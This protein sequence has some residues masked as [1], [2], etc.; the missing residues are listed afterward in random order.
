MTHNRQT[1]PN[2]LSKPSGLGR[3][4]HAS[5]TACVFLAL[6]P[7][8]CMSNFP[9]HESL[10]SDSSAGASSVVDV[11]EQ[12]PVEASARPR[13][14]DSAVSIWEDPLPSKPSHAI[15]LVSQV[16]SSAEPPATGRAVPES[17]NTT[18]TPQA[19]V[20]DRLSIGRVTLDITPPPG[21]FPPDHAAARF[22][23]EPAVDVGAGAGREW[24]ISSYSWTAPALCHEP[25]YFEERGLERHGQRVP[26]VQ[27]LISAVHF[28]GRVP[29]LPYL[30]AA[31][32]PGTPVSSLGQYRPGSCAPTDIE[33]P[34]ADLFAALV[35]SGV[36]VGLFLIVP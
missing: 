22:L 35:Q 18:A 31:E 29:A 30:M 27:P 7:V 24:G 17:L 33:L 12:A 10:T 11:E 13:E 36:L 15:T 21:D 6:L 5:A 32:P 28:F 34:P 14:L 19:V 8:G 26:V 3:R 23:N 20:G 9:N 2:P 16:Q 4:R 25:L 1:S